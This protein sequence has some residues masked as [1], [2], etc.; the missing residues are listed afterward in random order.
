MLSPFIYDQK[1]QQ[2]KSRDAGGTE[3]K[4]LAINASSYVDSEPKEMGGPATMV[5]CLPL[6]Y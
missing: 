4:K 3:Q 6:D 2:K 1:Y 5:L